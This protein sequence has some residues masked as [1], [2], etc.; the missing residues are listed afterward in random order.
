METQDITV[1]VELVEEIIVLA[2]AELVLGA[3]VVLN[4]VVLEILVALDK[5]TLVAE[6]VALLEQV[7]MVV[8][9]VQV[10]L[11]FAID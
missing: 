6:A 1:L 8:R 3:A 10:L 11:L 9:V 7:L 4:E 2:A 5:Q